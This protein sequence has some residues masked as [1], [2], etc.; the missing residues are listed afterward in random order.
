[1]V[2]GIIQGNLVGRGKRKM[3][4]NNLLVLKFQKSTG[5]DA[6]AC[7]TEKGLAALLESACHCEC[8]TVTGSDC[9]S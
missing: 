4:V 5:M 1:M 9:W 2:G 3:S 6:R 7:L 8:D